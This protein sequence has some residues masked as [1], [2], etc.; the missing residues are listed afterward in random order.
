[1]EDHWSRWR[2]RSD[3]D[4]GISDA[5]LEHVAYT[6]SSVAHTF[7]AYGTAFSLRKEGTM[8]P[9]GEAAIVARGRNDL[10]I[11]EWKAR[12]SQLGKEGIA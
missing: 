10:T 7:S 2:L 9:R 3:H 5:Q 8:Q 1:M 6:L 11:W 4:A 12:P